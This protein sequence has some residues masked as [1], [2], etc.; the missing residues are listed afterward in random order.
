[1]HVGKGLPPRVDRVAIQIVVDPGEFHGLKRVS[2]VGRASEYYST[3]RVACRRRGPFIGNVET[4][5]RAKLDLRALV[6][7]MNRIRDRKALPIPGLAE[8]LGD[9]ANDGRG[10]ITLAPGPEVKSSPGHH[11]RTVWS[12]GKPFLVVDEVSCA[13]ICHH[14]GRAPTSAA[15]ARDTDCQARCKGDAT[16]NDA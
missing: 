15:I 2:V 12:R 9:G 3:G 14:I 7:W 16:K 8:V 13:C 5:V 4:S 11:D 1:M 10:E 6:K